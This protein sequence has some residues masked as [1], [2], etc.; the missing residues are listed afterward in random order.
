[1]LLLLWLTNLRWKPLESALNQT[2]GVAE[3]VLSYNQHETAAGRPLCIDI[4]Q[5]FERIVHPSFSASSQPCEL[6][7]SDIH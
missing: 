2:G 4:A 5:L 1:M 6:L 3:D 7:F